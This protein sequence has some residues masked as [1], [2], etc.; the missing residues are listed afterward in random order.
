MIRS[1]PFEQIMDPAAREA[2]QIVERSV[3]EEPLIAG[4]FKFLEITFTKAGTFRVGHSLGFRPLDVI[5]TAK[6]GA[7]AVTWNYDNFTTTDV[8]LTVTGAC[9]VRAFIGAYRSE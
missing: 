2:F 1:I 8:E 5:Q 4:S 3:N 7:G 9:A 6:T